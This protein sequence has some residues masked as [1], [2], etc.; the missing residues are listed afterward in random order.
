MIFDCLNFIQFWHVLSEDQSHN[1][2]VP[3]RMQDTL[4]NHRPETDHV[5]SSQPIVYEWGLITMQNWFPTSHQDPG[6]SGDNLVI[7]WYSSQPQYLSSFSTL[8]SV[9]HSPEQDLKN[10]SQLNP[11]F[12]G[13]N[14]LHYCEN[15]SAQSW[16]TSNL[17]LLTLGDS[18]RFLL[19][20][21]LNLN[22]KNWRRKE[23]MAGFRNFESICSQRISLREET[24]VEAV[25]DV[26]GVEVGIFPSICYRG[27]MAHS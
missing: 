18:F 22:Y 6:S 10:T 12:L 1:D 26:P 21:L 9:I 11:A 25:I 14:V 4:T 8:R 27:Q 24:K 19:W 17:S 20:L 13:K 16:N 15:I 7:S 3:I 23:K 5:T 2:K